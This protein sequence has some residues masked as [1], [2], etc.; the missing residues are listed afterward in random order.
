MR[1]A[2]GSEL[3]LLRL[4]A[5]RGLRLL[6][7]SG[8]LILLSRGSELELVAEA[9]A[10][11]PR[12][13]S[14]PFEGSALGDFS[15]AQK[16]LSL[17]RPS[18]RETPWLTELG[19]A[20]SA[21]LVEPL[22][23]E[24]QP[25][26]MIALRQTGAG[27]DRSELAAASDLARSIVER[28]RAERSIERERLR[29]GVRARERERARWARELHDETIQGLGALRLLLEYAHCLNDPAERKKA[30]ESAVTEVDREI[31]ALRHLITE[32][33]PAALDDL[34]LVAALE[35]LA[36]R[37]GAIDG[38]TIQTEIELPHGVPRLSPEVESAVY[39]ITQEALTNA[40]KHSGAANARIALGLDGDRVVAAVTDDGS[41]FVVNGAGEPVVEPR[42]MNGLRAGDDLPPGLS[43]GV[44]LA[45][46]RERAELVG[47]ELEI[48]S[49]P[50]FGTTIRVSVPITARE[51]SEE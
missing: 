43:G 25:G 38:L 33:R 11:A 15:R 16:A 22:A 45:A 26:L 35:A 3:W 36:R 23:L 14:L 29:H 4:M 32:L 42:R 44:G 7:A 27:F 6:G 21:V 46:M 30:L 20:P 17:E 9:G 37:A 13:R 47:A 41:G 18:P 48:Q 50:G 10:A 31:E 49:E 24:E 39:R 1:A 40:A 2:S 5:E 51:R 12:V 19:L 34:G 28:V 8:L